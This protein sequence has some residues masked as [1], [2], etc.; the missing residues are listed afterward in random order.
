M[1]APSIVGAVVAYGVA[2]VLSMAVLAGRA[3]RPAAGGAAPSEPAP[4]TSGGQT[5]P[6][7]RAPFVRTALPSAP[8][9]YVLLWALTTG[10]RV[11]FE[12]SSI[13]PFLT[14]L[15]AGALALAVIGVAAR[16]QRG[17]GLAFLLFRVAL[18][19][20]ACLALSLKVIPVSF[21]S[22][23]L[24]HWAMEAGFALAAVT[25]WAFLA[26]A[27]ANRC[28]GPETALAGLPVVLAAALLL[29]TLLTLLP[30]DLKFALL[31]VVTSAFL[32]YEALYLGRSAVAYTS[33]ERAEGEGGADRPAR[34]EGDRRDRAPTVAET[35]ASL[36]D[37]C[38]LTRRESEVLLELARGHSSAYVAETLCVAPSTVRSHTK[39]IYAK[40]GV[41]SRDGML[42]LFRGCAG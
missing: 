21:V 26:Y 23:T 1:L 36:A 6:G 28:E 7:I 29:G 3:V 32:L 10:T 12:G 9:L 19:A 35:C 22:G 31:G 39:S 18:P 30:D 25:A 2:L 20:W 15:A 16:R 11:N 17:V 14:L 24:F 4:A 41:E 8:V 34:G 37:S 40:L 27:A 42:E 13:A 38:G 5:S 33:P